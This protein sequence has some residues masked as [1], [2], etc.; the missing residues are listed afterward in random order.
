MKILL[1]TDGYYPYPSGV[2]ELNYNRK[3]YLEEKG[4]KVDILTTSYGRED[5]KYP[6]YRVGKVIKIPANGSYITMSFGFDIP[7]KIKWFLQNNKYDIIH[8]SGPFPPDLSYWG[9]KYAPPQTGIIAE[10]Q[11]AGDSIL[12]SYYKEGNVI[13]NLNYNL[14]KNVLSPLFNQMFGKTFDKIDRYVAISQAAKIFFEIYIK[15]EYRII[16][17]GVDTKRFRKEGK[18]F[19]NIKKNP[20][21]IIFLGRLDKRKG[22]DRLLKSMPLVKKHIPDVHLYVGGKGPLE[23]EYKKLV[24][25]LNIEN[26]VSFLGFIKEE[27]IDAFYRSG[28]IYVSPATGG[29]TFGIVLIEAMATGTPIICSDI[30]GYREV[31]DNN[32]TGILVK[33]ED[34]DKLA[35]AII[36]LLKDKNKRE[37]LSN[38]GIEKVKN[39]YSWDVVINRTISMY[40]EVIEE[41]R[42]KYG[43]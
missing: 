12:R 6:A 22:L 18:V 7:A 15:G 10:F 27:E 14:S 3:K 2:S 23:K 43:L 30:P 31:V 24:K 42:R 37:I 13:D 28:A 26:N 33:T 41:K 20:N 40:K 38:N 5:S 9:L 17:V 1:I 21:S 11:A 35:N 36:E 32:K 25:D 34:K 29:E 4:H 19:D 8:L 39:K 16:P